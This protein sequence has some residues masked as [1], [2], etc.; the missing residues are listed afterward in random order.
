MSP[1]LQIGS[2]TLSGGAYIVIGGAITRNL[3]A[4]LGQPVNG[5][6]SMQTLRYLAT[7]IDFSTHQIT[8]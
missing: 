2:L 3:T 8:P 5:V 1:A 6:I 7:E 4:I